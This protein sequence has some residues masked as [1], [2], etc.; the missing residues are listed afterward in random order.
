MGRGWKNFEI[1]SRESTHCTKEI[2]DRNMNVKGNSN[3]GSDRSEEHSWDSLYH[4]WE[5]G[6][7]YEQNTSRNMNVKGT[8]SEALGNEEHVMLLGTGA[9]AILL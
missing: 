1:Y 5:Y 7:H 9:K 6:E 8:S 3:E 2:V 4:F